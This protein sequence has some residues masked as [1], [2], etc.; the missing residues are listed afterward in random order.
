[1]GKINSVEDLIRW[2]VFNRNITDPDEIVRYFS[3]DATFLRH[4]IGFR[5]AVAQFRKSSYTRRLSLAARVTNKLQLMRDPDKAPSPTTVEVLVQ[6]IE[7][8]QGVV[9]SLHSR[10]QYLERGTVGLQ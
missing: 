7:E 8:L 6:Q 2:A 10:V 3:T 9:Q 1:M 5:T 4:S